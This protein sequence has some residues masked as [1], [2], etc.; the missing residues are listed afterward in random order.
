MPYVIRPP[1]KKL[2]L[3]LILSAVLLA[4]LVLPAAAGAS[5]PATPTTKPFL[6]FD[7]SANYSLVPG[8]DFESQESDWTL[9]DAETVFGNSVFQVGG[10]GDDRSLRIQAGGE[11]RSARFCVGAEHPSFRF[12]ARGREGRLVVKLRWRDAD[13]ELHKAVVGTLRASEGYTTWQPTPSLALAPELPLDELGGTARVRI[14]FANP[15]DEGGSWRIDDVYID[16][17]RR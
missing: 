2:R 6:Q 13:D 16:P 14:V 15:D 7:D 10:L 12:F 9:M 1:V 17:Y 5:C 3:S 8:G 11:A 4:A